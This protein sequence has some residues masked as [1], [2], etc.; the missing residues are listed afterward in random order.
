MRLPLALAVGFGALA[1]SACGGGGGGP[2]AGGSGGGG[3][4]SPA[5]LRILV[6]DG[7]FPFDY[8]E[9][10]SVV[11]NEVRVHEKNSDAWTTVFTGAK[12]IDL[13]PLQNGVSELLV[14]AEIEPGTY[15]M[16]RLLVDAGTVTL[17]PDAVVEGDSHV[18]DTASG[19]L[20]FPSGAQTGIKVDIE[21]DIVVTTQL[22]GDLVL[23]F[24][25]SKNFVFNGPVTHNPGVKRVLFTPHV[26]ATNASTNGSFTLRVLSDQ[27][28]P[29][30]PSDDVPIEGATVEVFNATDDPTVDPSIVTVGTDSLGVVTV[31]V[32]PG[33]YQVVVSAAGHMPQTV[34]GI[35]VDLANLTDV[36]DVTLEAIGEITGTVM[37]NAGTDDTS[38]DVVIEGAAVEVHLAGDVAV[39]TTVFTDASGAFQ[40]PGLAA[41]SYDLFVTAAGFQPG[42]LLAVP[43]EIGGTGHLI[44]LTPLTAPVEGTVTDAEGA[45]LEGITVTIENEF[46]VA[47][48]TGAT[49]ADGMFTAELPTGDYTVKFDDGV[50]EKTHEIEIVGA[51]PLPPPIVVDETF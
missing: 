6:T 8:V 3:G 43:A 30:D 38:D 9:S 37:S 28:T 22:S 23:D 5:T 12:E 20:K 50:T 31:S 45:P 33:D 49:D 51:D 16:V 26:R 21:N 40:V 7:P 18:F 47:V 36:G 42:E 25:L 44:L 27:L 24:D 46:G 4:G 32:L 41:G 13:V 10:A 17:T 39:L 34:T 29:L 15:D 1:L 11:I 14:E 19:N 48:F 2:A 35:H